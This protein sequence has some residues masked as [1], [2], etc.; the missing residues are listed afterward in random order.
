[1]WG[2][3]A[4][5][6]GCS[7]SWHSF[8]QKQQS[9]FLQRE[10]LISYV[11][12]GSS[13]NLTRR[14][15]GSLTGNIAVMGRMSPFYSRLDMIRSVWVHIS[16]I[17]MQEI[18]REDARHDLLQSAPDGKRPWNSVEWALSKIHVNIDSSL[19]ISIVC[20]ATIY[21]CCS[22]EVSRCIDVSHGWSAWRTWVCSRAQ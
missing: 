18:C 1:M 4:S 11:G 10:T 6:R 14:S 17:D 2:S 5:R 8:L 15:R 12:L 20:W 9:K 13:W 21:I 22:A 19:S 7:D 16:I 3:L